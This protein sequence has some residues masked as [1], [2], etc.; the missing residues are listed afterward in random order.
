MLFKNIQ[1]SFHG[2]RKPPRN[3]IFPTIPFIKIFN[4]LSIHSICTS[5]R[6][7]YLDQFFSYVLQPSHLPLFFFNFEQKTVLI[8][9]LECLIKIYKRS[10]RS[11]FLLLNIFHTCLI[12]KLCTHFSHTG[13][14]M[15]FYNFETVP[16]FPPLYWMVVLMQFSTMLKILPFLLCT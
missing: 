15:S 2:G 5:K 3:S 10:V 12:K 1:S 13:V 4:P 9:I 6:I 14:I 8:S 16:D 11:I 7:L